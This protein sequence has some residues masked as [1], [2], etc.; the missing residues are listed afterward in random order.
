MAVASTTPD[1]SLD[2]L[3]LNPEQRD[4]VEHFEGPMLVLA[5]AGSG[6]TRVLTVRVAHLI[7]THG[8]PPERVLAVTF[9]N[10]AAGEMRER[11]EALL[12]E[13]PAGLW[14]GTFHSFGAWLLRQHATR[15]GWERRFSIL[16]ADESLRLI[17]RVAQEVGI[18]TDRVR[19]QALR[20]AVSDA[21]NALV[22][23]GDYLRAAA[24]V[25]P[26]A[27]QRAVAQ[28]YPAYQKRLREQNCFDFDDLLV[29]PVRLLE[30]SP[31]ILARYQERFAFIS[32][33]EY[34]DTN[35][36][37]YRLISL[38]GR[39]HGN[40][41]VVGDEDQAI[42]GWRGADIRNILD[43][44]KD[45]P[46]AKVV[47]LERNYRCGRHILDAANAVIR[48]NRKRKGKTLTAECGEGDKV[49]L[50]EFSSDLDEARWIVDEVERLRLEDPQLRFR[51]FAVLYRTNAQSRTM[52]EA[53]RRRGV[54]YQIVG[55]LSFYERREIRD[56]L[57][58]LRLIANPRD[59][60]AF[61]RVVNYPK[62]GI[63]KVSQERLLAWGRREG[64]AALEAA[65]QATKADAVPTAAQGRLEAFAGLIGRYHEAANR[66][67]VGELVRR[68]VEELEV[69]EALRAEG[70]DGYERVENVQ[71]LVASATEFEGREAPGAVLEGFNDLELFLQ[72]VSLVTDVDRHDP[73]AD[74]VLL[75]TLHAA[76]GLE[77]PNVFISGLEDGLFPH[78]RS[79][80]DA[81]ALE[82]ERRLFY[83]GI[84]RA[85]ERLLLSHAQRRRRGRDL[86]DMTPSMFVREIPLVLLEMRTPMG[87]VRRSS[88]GWGRDNSVADDVFADDNLNQDAPRM[89]PG[90]RVHHGRFGSGVIKDVSGFGG[91]ARVV[92]DFDEGGRRKLVARY[93]G[94]ER[95]IDFF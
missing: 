36:A 30:G 20:A 15:V 48:N 85:Q 16:D 46:G 6:K 74:S 10:K 4:A 57:A 9:T 31:E 58:Y 80:H 5:G 86:A 23:P 87:P 82:E 62:R 49:V 42:Y 32:V 67:P 94:L 89:V 93:A 53:L 66:M 60:G 26:D 72:Q 28:L 55:G 12:G 95:D 65:A 47:R 63:G 8:V 76:K 43:F 24:P 59:D 35:A 17:K 37:Q 92:V 29:Q 61:E 25:D 70:P 91:D 90:E 27:F 38:L 69:E 84:T 78:E 7:D 3:A 18:D 40:V 71:E 34:Q 13:E 41:M 11:I 39:G 1:F 81:D 2:R 22:E 33:D 73:T 50:S 77:F 19:P 51:D 68:L 83:V 54:P 64:C 45:F 56:V 79:R 52:E 14:V 88:G 21:K 75:M 44:E